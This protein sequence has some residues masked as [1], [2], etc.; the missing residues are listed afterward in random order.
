MAESGLGVTVPFI[1]MATATAW[2][3][4]SPSTVNMSDV[5]FKEDNTEELSY[6]DLNDIPEFLSVRAGE[7]LSL[8]LDH[9]MITILSRSIGQFKN[10][11]SLDI[12]YNHMAFISAEITLL[13]SLRTLI[14]R[15]NNLDSDSLP[16]SFGSMRSLQ[17]LNL[18]GNR[19]HEVPMCITELTNLQYLYMGGNQIEFVP[20]ELNSLTK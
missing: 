11:I 7:L 14:A 3:A 17:V 20:P 8:H 10:L 18:S 12:S 4:D 5:C 13:T 16:K 15:N 19:F 2:N 1:S 6:A 9:N